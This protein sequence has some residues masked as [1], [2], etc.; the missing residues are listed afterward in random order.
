MKKRDRPLRVLIAA[1]GTGGHL[2]PAQ[3]LSER[4]L[5]EGTSEVLFAGHQLEKSPFFAHGKIPFREIRSA[6][7][8]RKFF[9]LKEATRGFFQ[10]LRVI[11]QFQPDI[12]VGFGSYHSFPVLLAAAFLRKKI[13]L[14]EANCLLGKVN[15]LFAPVSE[16]IAVQ[17]P[18][19]EKISKQVLVP[20]LPWT[21]LPSQTM[22]QS[23]ARR[24]FQLDPELF[25]LLI[26]GGSQGAAFLNESLG[27][28]TS[29]LKAR[30][31]AF[32]VIHLTGKEPEKVA[33]DY[34]ARGVQAAVKAFEKEMPIAY[35]AA[36]L[37]ICRSG[38]G[39]I[40]EIIRFQKPALLI[41][42]PFAAEDHQ[43]INGEFLSNR[44]G[45]ARL[46]L[47]SGANPERMA[48][49]IERL[50]EQ[51]SGHTTSLKKESL[52]TERKIDFNTLVQNL[53][54]SS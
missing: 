46:L 35:R 7:L 1:G 47:Q 17:F 40:A 28:L 41:P 24:F 18:I 31:R 48:D 10:S 32:Q 8:K 5:K 30:G 38:A 29:L 36:D 51:R 53:G 22:S 49:E 9:F 54:T 2:F 6:S 3:Q 44:V 13:V 19:G 23:E 34:R 33:E 39:T 45:G 52:A 42:Y 50:W 25:T 43:R 14:F 16:K 15:R 27:P 20:L 4:L 11:R 21:E 12:V 37:V 26:F